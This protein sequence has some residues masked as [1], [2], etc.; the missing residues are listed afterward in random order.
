MLFPGAPPWNLPLTQGHRVTFFQRRLASDRNGVATNEFAAGAGLTGSASA[1]SQVRMPVKRSGSP[2]RSARGRR[3]RPP[4]LAST[5]LASTELGFDIEIQGFSTA[6]GSQD[7]IDLRRWSDHY[8]ERI[9]RRGEHLP[10]RSI[11]WRAG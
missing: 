5:E 4:G 6:A 8:G 11:Q 7:V 10:G 2:V 9:D 3:G 1:I